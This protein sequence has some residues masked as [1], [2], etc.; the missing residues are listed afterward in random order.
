M[1]EKTNQVGIYS[2]NKVFDNGMLELRDMSNA[3]KDRPIGELTLFVL[4]MTGSST[5]STQN[6]S[7]TSIG[8]KVVSCNVASSLSIWLVAFLGCRP[9][10]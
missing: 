5:S 10:A 4:S 9:S 8:E 6:V 1:I 2:W 3:I 7:S